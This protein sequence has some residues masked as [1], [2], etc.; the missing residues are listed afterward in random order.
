MNYIHSQILMFFNFR[1]QIRCSNIDKVSSSKRN[2]KGETSTFLEGEGEPEQ[3]FEAPKEAF[4]KAGE[5]GDV[6]I[7]VTLSNACPFRLPQDK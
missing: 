1:H 5:V 3:I 2:K 7:V 4:K 6:S